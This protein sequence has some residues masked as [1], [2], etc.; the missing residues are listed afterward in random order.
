MKTIFR[1][2][3]LYRIYIYIYIYIYIMS[4]NLADYLENT[5]PKPTP[6]ELK[7]LEVGEFYVIKHKE[8]TVPDGRPSLV[9]IGKLIDNAKLGPL[10]KNPDYNTYS[11]ILDKYLR[12]DPKPYF[13]IYSSAH[14]RASSEIDP[15]NKYRVEEDFRNPNF[16]EFYK[17][18]FE[19]KETKDTEKDSISDKNF[20]I[21]QPLEETGSSDEKAGGKK[22]KTKKGK[23]GKKSKDS[24][25]KSKSKRKNRK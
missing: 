21:L 10:V 9:H 20:T 13:Y 14:K 22:R 18:S 23:R 16:Y 19:I 24:R 25:K 12:N 2:Y 5:V 11:Q 6:V 7:D 3:I 8:V 15:A 1:I 17:P 4:I